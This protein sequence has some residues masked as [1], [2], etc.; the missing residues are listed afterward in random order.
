MSKREPPYRHPEDA[1]KS[2]GK[3][4]KYV[5]EEYGY[6]LRSLADALTERGFPIGH[7]A[8]GHWETG[9]NVPDAIW[10]W[11]LARVYGTPID[12]LLS[13]DVAS[14]DALRVL[15]TVKDALRR[16]SI[17]TNPPAVSRSRKM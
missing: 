13:D 9:T 6:T 2:L 11:H 14:L 10:A 15:D 5:R 4:L 8:I 16:S 12:V 1:R 17:G 3:R 7:G